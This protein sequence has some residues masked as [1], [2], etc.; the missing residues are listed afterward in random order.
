MFIATSTSRKL[1][2][3]GAK[4]S[5]ASPN[6]S[7][8][9]SLR[10]CHLSSHDLHPFGNQGKLWA[11]IY[12]RFAAGTSRAPEAAGLLSAPPPGGESVLR[13]SMQMRLHR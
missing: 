8:L 9:R 2:S 7:L 4:C 10:V 13:P 3:S 6:L 11:A 1:S 5:A 12:R